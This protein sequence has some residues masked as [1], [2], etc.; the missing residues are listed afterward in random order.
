MAEGETVFFGLFAFFAVLV[1]LGIA[2]NLG[3]LPYI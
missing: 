2:Q 1:L 3:Y